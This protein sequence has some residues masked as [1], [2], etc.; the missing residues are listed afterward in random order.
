[1]SDLP[2]VKWHTTE[3]LQI[4]AAAWQRRADSIAT[5]RHHPSDVRNAGGVR[6]RDRCGRFDARMA[7]ACR[8]ELARR[9]KEAG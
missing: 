2:D 6:D 5:E 9:R 8:R 7:Q 3:W 4:E 1:M